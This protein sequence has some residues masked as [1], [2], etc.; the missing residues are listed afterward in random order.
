M[1]YSGAKNAGTETKIREF[2]AANGSAD[3]VMNCDALAM[4]CVV[5]P[6]FVNETL[7]CHGSC[8]TEEG[9]S[10]AQVIF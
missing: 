9:E 3:S 7:T 1:R 10:R 5:H 6:E 8:L 4:M 2:Y